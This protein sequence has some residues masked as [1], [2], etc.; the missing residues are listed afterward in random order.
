MLILQSQVRQLQAQLRNS[1][2][3]DAKVAENKIRC[4]L[5]EHFKD[6]EDTRSPLEKLHSLETMITI[7]TVAM[8]CGADDWLEIEEFGQARESMLREYFGVAPKGIP[9]H[10]TFGRVFQSQTSLCA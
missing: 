7:A 1:T 10:D 6:S 9:S 2:H 8:I 4:N 3:F 5:S